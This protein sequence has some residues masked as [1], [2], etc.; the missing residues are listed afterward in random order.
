MNP[1]PLTVGL[2]ED[3]AVTA[4][5]LAAF[6]ERNPQVERVHIWNSGEDFLSDPKSSPP[7]VLFIDLDLP[8]ISGLELLKVVPRELPDASSIV[9]TSSDEVDDVFTAIKAGASGYILKSSPP[10][11]IERS[12]EASARDGLCLSPKI[13]G[14]I[15]QEMERG[16]S[17]QDDGGIEQLTDREKEILECLARGAHTK[18]V[19]TKLQLSYETIRSHVKNIYRKLHVGTRTEAVRRY[20]RFSI[21]Q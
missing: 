20:V 5:Y 9:L 1:E 13:A 2:V 10:G 12:L 8:G 21:N 19:A 6:L 4:R 17:I 14:M 18:E 15:W 7:N 3:D 11:E 16:S